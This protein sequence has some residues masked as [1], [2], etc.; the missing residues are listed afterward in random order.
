MKHYSRYKK[1]LFCTD[2]SESSDRAF[3]YAYGVAKRDGSL[4]YIL[5]VMEQ[6]SG[7][8]LAE[9][10]LDSVTLEDARKKCEKFL[11]RSYHDIHFC[12]NNI[13]PLCN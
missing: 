5:H 7:A 12:D 8:K 4:L 9:V 13:L 11:D 10:F 1:I 6:H 3:E 2:F